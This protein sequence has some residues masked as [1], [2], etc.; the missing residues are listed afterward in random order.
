MFVNASSFGSEKDKKTLRHMYSF[1]YDV[2]HWLY[3]Q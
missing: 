1:L 2:A 3:K